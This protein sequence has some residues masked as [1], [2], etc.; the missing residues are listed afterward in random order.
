MSIPAEDKKD[1]QHQ[2]ENVYDIAN[3]ADELIAVLDRY[4]RQEQAE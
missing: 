3:Y 2:I 1:V 4:L